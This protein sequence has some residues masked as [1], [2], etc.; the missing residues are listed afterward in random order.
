LTAA[1]R[2]SILAAMTAQFHP[3][4]GAA[5]PHP[6]LHPDVLPLAGLIGTWRG[7]GVGEYPTISP[8]R[9]GEEVTF[10]STGKPFLAYEQ[11][12]WAIDDGR[13]L[14]SEAGFWRVKPDGWVEVVLAHPTGIVEV[15]EGSLDGGR[16]ELSSTTV[17]GTRTAKEVI[18]LHR[19]IH[20]GD[21]VLTYALSMAAV[22]QPLQ[23]HLTAGLRR[24]PPG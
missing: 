10:R 9:Y 5:A 15:S 24:V 12:T 16:L 21:D 1:Q 17:A 2:R 7:E 3:P 14:H 6:S 8:F 19:D 11:R 23:R 22:G 4:A 13:L 18:A 20:L